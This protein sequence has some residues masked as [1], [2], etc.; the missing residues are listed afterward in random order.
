MIGLPPPTSNHPSEFEKAVKLLS[1]CGKRSRR[2]F[3]AELPPIKPR[4]PFPSRE[5]VNSVSAI[6]VLT[7]F[8]TTAG[9]DITPWKQMLHLITL[10]VNWGSG[11][12][13]PALQM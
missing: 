11:G 5:S 12:S 8:S 1:N 2:G 13:S 3:G 10:P 4:D 7:C 9:P 6:N